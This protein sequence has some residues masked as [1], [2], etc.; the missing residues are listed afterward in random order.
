MQL[1]FLVFCCVLG[2]VH[3]AHLVSFLLCFGWGPCSSSCQFSVVF[4]VGV[5]VAHLF[6]FL[7]C[8]FMFLFCLSSSCVLCVQCCQCLQI[9]HSGLSIRLSLM[10]IFVRI[11][12]NVIL[13]GQHKLH[14][15]LHIQLN[16]RT[17]CQLSWDQS[18]DQKRKLSIQTI[19]I[20]SMN[21]LLFLC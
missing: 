20:C 5:H 3:V 17:S 21:S 4:W 16:V 14:L 6:S 8:V 9:S 18:N 10:F 13:L 11:C 1:I 2:G 15:L 12:S 7:C 19:L